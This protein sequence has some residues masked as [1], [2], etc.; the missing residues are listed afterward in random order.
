MADDVRVIPSAEAPWPDVLAVFG[1]RG[2]ASTCFCRFFKVRGAEFDAASPGELRDAL[3]AQHADAAAAAGGS[4]APASVD[5]GVVAYLGDEPVGWCAVEPRT[6]YTRLLRSQVLRG[7]DEPADAA[8]VWAVTCFVVR[9]AFRRRGV[10]RALL[11]AAVAQARRGGARVVEA[12][13]VDAAAKRR[14]SA[15]ELYHGPLSLFESAGFR[16][17]ARPSPTRAVVALDA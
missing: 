13:P 6:S 2:D 11:D 8:D 3:C 12:Y 1:E 7:S 4:R 14:P 16:I 17:V 9:P 15:S 5:P 10:S